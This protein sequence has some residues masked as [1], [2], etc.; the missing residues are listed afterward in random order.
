MRSLILVLFLLAWVSTPARAA[1]LDFSAPYQDLLSFDADTSFTSQGGD[2]L[3]F[4]HFSQPHILTFSTPVTLNSLE[5]NGLPWPGN[6][7]EYT[8][9]Y[10]IPDL[11]VIAR[12]EQGASVWTGLVTI[13]Q[14][15]D[16]GAWATL[17]INK[18]GVK[19]LFFPAQTPNPSLDQYWGT[20]TSVD[21]IRYNDPKPTPIPGAF[22]LLGSGL[23]VLAGLRGRKAGG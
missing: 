7:Y 3:V 21:N 14:V 23:A 17:A 2:H 22:L 1:I 10:L 9:P 20:W 6:P 11:T 13:S 18:E 4:N 8:K 12:N 19:S 15:L 16:W 5:L